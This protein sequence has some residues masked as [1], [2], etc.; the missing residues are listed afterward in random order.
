MSETFDAFILFAEMRTGSNRLEQLINTASGVSCMGE[1]YN[2]TFI[3]HP[4][5]SSLAGFDLAARERDPV[6]CFTAMVGA[7]PDLVGFRFFHDHDP[8]ILDRVMP[9]PRVAKVILRRNPLDSYISR[10]IATETGQ[11]K[12]TDVKHRRAAK[13][14]FDGAE[15]AAMARDWQGFYARL[16]VLLQRHGQA[17]FQLGY[18]DLNDTAAIN[19]LLRYLGVEGE[20][21][22]S[23]SKLKPQNP[24]PAIEK[25]ENPG[26]MQAALAQLDA[27]GLDQVLHANPGTSARVPQFC[28]TPGGEVL[29]MPLPGNAA[30]ELRAALAQSAG[31]STDDLAGGFDQRS[32][33]AWY[34]SNPQHRR[35]TYVRHPLARAHALFCR[36]VL[37]TNRPRFAPIRRMLRNRYDIPLP[38]ADAW[39]DYTSAAHAA[40]FAAWLTFLKGCL[41]GQTSLIPPRSWGLQSDA[42][43]AL[44]S[45]SAP[46]FILREGDHR[47]TLG[48]LAGLVGLAGA[49]EV[50]TQPD[51]PFALSEI[52]SGEL[53]SLARKAYRRDYLL[54]GF[55]D[56]SAD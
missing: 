30:P 33:R 22:P 6:G 40:A 5:Q 52:Y 8:R 9:D 13:V 3:G 54:F 42:V 37:P 53:D 50:Q 16:R 7:T 11:W 1:V 10:K 36:E 35:F 48:D 44:A 39:D 23:L 21:D 46:D 41:A 38:R 12:L 26:E 43:Q 56:W 34:R 18:D 27:F 14:H 15:F 19:G 49:F 2:P 17:A 28:A 31:V 29:F 20:V 47:F 45:V 4:K 24:A 51:T 55:S 32:L 25:V